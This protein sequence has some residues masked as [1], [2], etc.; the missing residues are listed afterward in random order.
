MGTAAKS[1]TQ[2]QCLHT[3]CT[4]GIDGPPIE[5]PPLVWDGAAIISPI[6]QLL[7][8]HA[9]Q[10]ETTFLVLHQAAKADCCAGVIGMR[11]LLVAEDT[12]EVPPLATEAK[13]KDPASWGQ[14]VMT[15][16]PKTGPRIR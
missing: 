5:L 13:R 14:H 3:N 4:M 12:M 11:R 9:R 6:A 7:V 1:R 15:C 2:A 16:S 10:F 8:P